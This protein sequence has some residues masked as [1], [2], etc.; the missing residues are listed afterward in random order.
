MKIELMKNLKHFSV[1]KLLDTI[2]TDKYILIVM[3]NVLGGDLLTFL[4][5]L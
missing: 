4:N 2:A 3:E 1:F 5:S